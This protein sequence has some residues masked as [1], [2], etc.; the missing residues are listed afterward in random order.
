MYNNDFITE[1]L[2][3][4]LTQKNIVSYSTLLTIDRKEDNGR[5]S[6]SKNIIRTTDNIFFPNKK[7][8]YFGVFILHFM[9]YMNTIQS[10]IFLQKKRKLNIVG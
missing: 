9:D 8:V 1:L 2:P 10:T 7:T 3:H 5:K 6:S 4:M